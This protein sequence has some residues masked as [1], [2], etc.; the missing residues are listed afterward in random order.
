MK[1]EIRRAVKEDENSIK[2]LFIEMLQTIYATQSEEGYEDGYLDKFFCG[3]EDW[4]CVA[5]ANGSVVA[6]L[7]IEVHCEQERFV[8]LDD[9]S[10]SAP[11][12]NHGIGTELICTAERFAE[13]TGI[14][15]IYF[16][17]EKSNL[18]ALRLYKRLGYSIVNEEKSRFRMAKRY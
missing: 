5:G 6:Y 7:S 17:V 9:L 3:T 12:R 2:G 18:S 15:T 8:Y 10:V 11:Y 4:I 13:E 14:P 16:H 1:W